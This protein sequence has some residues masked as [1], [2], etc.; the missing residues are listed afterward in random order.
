MDRESLI[1][2][3]KESLKVTPD[4]THR[5]IEARDVLLD[6]V[7]TRME[8]HPQ[9]AVLIGGNPIRMMH[10]NHRNH[11]D[12]MATVFQ[13][14]S[15]EMLAKTLPWVYRAYGTH[16]FSFDYFPQVL[17][18]WKEA[19][20]KHLAPAA[21]AEINAVYDWMLHHH[22]HMIELST[23]V[24]DMEEAYPDLADE[25]GKFGACL[26]S[27]D[28]QSCMKIAES[29]L[30]RENGQ[31]TLYLGLI[32]PVM[33]EIGRLWEQD[34][35]STAEEHLATSMVGRILAGLYA[36]LP[37]PPPDRGKAIVTSAPNEFHELGG[38]MLADMLEAAGWDILYLG[39]NTPAEELIRL[40]RK[41][42]P[43]F[44]AISLTMPFGMDRVAAIIST[45][46]GA[47]DLG[48]IKILVGGSA[49]NSDRNLWRQ[50]G[51]DAWAEDPKSAIRQVLTW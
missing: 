24:S 31:E 1:K 37:I 19:V 15:Y 49:F 41:T 22:R 6:E 32:Q 40:I 13:F 18:T 29:I 50:I 28:F 5:Y 38:R 4:A 14:N 48:H 43:R 26:L 35:I 9:I 42:N 34:K 7:N 39:A 23:V 51:A 16:G 46:K 17:E 10:D 12:F 47:P 20:K 33:Y 27:A 11:I 8:D 25:R 21:A 2:E 44:L 45:L 3:A 30:S 36:K